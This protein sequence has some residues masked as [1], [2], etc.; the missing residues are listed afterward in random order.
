MADSLPLAALFRSA[1][2]VLDVGVAFGGEVAVGGNSALENDFLGQNRKDY[3][4][5]PL[6]I[7]LDLTF[8]KNFLPFLLF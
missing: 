1:F 4:L 2:G 3:P 8:F 5:H 6:Q 7:F